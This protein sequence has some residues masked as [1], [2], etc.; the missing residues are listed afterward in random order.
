MDAL[1]ADSA[2]ALPLPSDGEGLRA[3]VLALLASPNL[4][5]R[6]WITSQ[7]DRYVQGNTAMARPDAVG[8]VRVDEETGRGVAIA[9]RSNDRYTKLDPYEGARQSVVAAYRAVAVAGAEP[10][11]VTDGLNFG[12]PEDPDAMWQLVEAVRGLA[13]ACQELGVPVTGGNVSLYNGTGEPGRIDSSINP[14]AIVGVL[15][16]L[17]DVARATPSGWREGGQALYLLGTTRAELDGSRFAELHGHL[18]G[19]PPAVDLAAERLLAEVMVAA[20]RDG[21][22]DAARE[23]GEGG[24]AAAVMLGALRYG[25][26]ARVVLDEVAERDGLGPAAAMLSESQGRVLC[27]VPRTEEERFVAM[28]QARGL[29]H[30]RGGVTEDSG[31]VEVQ[32]QFTLPLAE[33]REAWEAPLPARFG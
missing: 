25:V 32:G 28:L 4:S 14:T 17:D 27:A 21:L 33:A 6:E 23:V 26:G 12:S 9:T 15:G 30:A 3:T 2:A 19:L 18:G 11:A 22:V 20:S 31:A 16:V 29:A 5:S 24:L 13:D 10:R 1:Q 8:V 7:Y